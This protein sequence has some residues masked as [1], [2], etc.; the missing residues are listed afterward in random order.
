[1]NDIRFSGLPMPSP[2]DNGR[3]S[4]QS[5]KLKDIRVGFHQ[6]SVEAGCKAKPFGPDHRQ[7]QE[8]NRFPGGHV[9][10][11]V[12]VSDAQHKNIVLQG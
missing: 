7:S 5:M 2:G 10:I 9:R 1:M 4:P 8:G 3:V 12:L 6:L 11:R